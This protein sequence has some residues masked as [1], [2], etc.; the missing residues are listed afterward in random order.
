MSKGPIRR[1][2][3]I[4]PFGV[5][6]MV[7]VKD[8]TSVI[9]AGLDHWYER[10]GGA[11]ASSD[12]DEDEYKVEEWRLQKRLNVDHFRLP[13]DYRRRIR[14]HDIPNSALT[15]P[16]LRFPTWHFCPFCKSL[17]QMFSSVK[18]HQNCKYCAEKKQRR[19]LFQVPF[20][21]ICDHGH[22][23]DF[24]WREWVHKTAE[25]TCD[26]RMT[27]V[28]TG[29]SSLADQIVTCDC[30]KK[31]S[32]AAIMMA[33]P[34]GQESFLSK[35]LSESGEKYRCNG[36]KAWLGDGE[37]EACERPL[38]GSL[39]NASNVYFARTVSAIYLPRA[40][41]GAPAELLELLKVPP[42]STFMAYVRSMGNEVTAQALKQVQSSWLKDYSEA[43]VAK[44]IGALSEGNVQE[45][46]E[47]ESA[48]VVAA[49]IAFR[50]SEYEVLSVKQNQQELLTVCRP[51]TDYSNLLHGKIS[52]VSLVHKL[53]ETIVFAGFSRVFPD[54]GD[55]GLSVEQHKWRLWRRAP[56][57]AKAWLPANVVFGE[58]L[59][60]KFNEDALRLWENQ[61]TVIEL[62]DK[63]RNRYRDQNGNRRQRDFAIEPRF[64]LL[65]TFAHILINQLTFECGYGSSSLR[66]RLY[67]ST[68]AANPMAGILIY[69]AAGDSE[70]TMGGLVR[71]GHPGYFEPVIQKAVRNAGW[72]STDPVCMEIGGHQGQGPD[73]S[74]GAAC[75]SCCL[76][77]ETA[78]EHF[79]R[80]LD[81]TLIVGSNEDR[82]IG[83]FANLL[84]GN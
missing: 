28:A 23:Q 66:E 50:R 84:L 14:G 44:A 38:R 37:L 63:L 78:C 62:V 42:I 71:M 19:T 18:G 39:R 30:G 64:V 15:I 72:C 1:G 48:D 45:D 11:N 80:F 36:N 2:Q 51:Q 52:Q 41:H 26:R 21:A 47:Q 82:Q 69:T 81:R 6:A 57:R 46:L 40:S 27:L 75:H 73:G 34:D 74:N 31:R 59:F 9:A 16:F 49:E 5:G 8:G 77:P 4:A 56:E 32:L 79:N 61:K 12:V 53:R 68:N 76:M 70:G 43:E 83:F 67:I 35:N 13:P 25:P 29:G 54:D 58:G 22:I 60:I 10:E 20:V 17:Q 3:L 24:P 65:H 33:S 7:V 55:G